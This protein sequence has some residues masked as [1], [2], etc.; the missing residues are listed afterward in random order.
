MEVP[1]K[2]NHQQLQEYVELSRHFQGEIKEIT[3]SKEAIDW[4]ETLREQIAKNLNISTTKNHS[5]PIFM[6][7]KLVSKG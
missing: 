2:F 1:P 7:V 6:G 3:V 5:E 4:Y